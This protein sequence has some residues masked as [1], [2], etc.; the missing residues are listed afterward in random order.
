MQKIRK[1][2]RLLRQRGLRA[3]IARIL[4]GSGR[5]AAVTPM[6]FIE[7]LPPD[8]ARQ[9]SPKALVVVGGGVEQSR[10]DHVAKRLAVSGWS[11]KVAPFADAEMCRHEMQTARAVFGYGMLP[12]GVAKALG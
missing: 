11:V 5:T 8:H 7:T 3:F 1:A 10:T 2:L 12:A 6:E 9:L 4:R